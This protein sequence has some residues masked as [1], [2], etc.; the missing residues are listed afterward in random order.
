MIVAKAG[1]ADSARDRRA[2]RGQVQGGRNVVPPANAPLATSHAGMKGHP[3]VAG[4]IAAKAVAVHLV[5]DR[6]AKAA[7]W[8]Q[9]KPGGERRP[10]GERSFGDKPR[11]HEGPSG[12]GRDDRREGGRGGFGKGPPRGSARPSFGRDAPPSGERSF[13]DKPRR[14][15]GPSGGGRD[16]RREG[17]RGGFGK[18]PPRGRERPGAGRDEGGRAGP[19]SFG[20][21]PRRYGSGD[22]PREERGPDT[23][24]KGPPRKSPSAWRDDDR[25]GKRTF[26]GPRRDELGAESEP[27]RAKR[28]GPIQDRKG[29]RVLVERVPTQAPERTAEPRP[30]F[31]PKFKPRPGAKPTS[32]FP[33]DRGGRGGPRPSR[34]R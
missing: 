14:H 2:A 7:H 15:E 29:R 11:R 33:R 13:G 23:R 8:L 4:T 30:E 12:G 10:S 18:G 3:A 1:A 28:S 6:R 32:K 34:P 24:A 16:D 21:A 27:K 22:S 20:D 19:R 17:G 26:H 31:K 5:R 9:F 25:P